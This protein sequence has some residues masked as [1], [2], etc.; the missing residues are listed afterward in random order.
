MLQSNYSKIPIN[1]DSD[2]KMSQ[3]VNNKM[4]VIWIPNYTCFTPSVLKFGLTE[5]PI[6]K[7]IT[8]FVMK[9]EIS[10]IPIKTRVFSSKISIKWDSDQNIFDSTYSKTQ[11]NRD[12]DQVS[13]PL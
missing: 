7:N 13:P 4:P 5:I 12:F 9:S 10:G 3:S 1:R 2:Q 11:I 8:S 6:Y